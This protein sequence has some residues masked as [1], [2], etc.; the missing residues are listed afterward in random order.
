MMV[1]NVEQQIEALREL[2]QGERWHVEQE[3][4]KVAELP[5]LPESTSVF[6]L[7]NAITSAAKQAE[8]ARRLDIESLAGQVLTRHVGRA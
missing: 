5:A 3:L 7:V 8:P 4:L 1:E 6:R 2:T